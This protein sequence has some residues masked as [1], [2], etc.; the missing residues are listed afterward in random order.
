MFLCVT[1]QRCPHKGLAPR[2]PGRSAVTGIAQVE[3]GGRC[4]LRGPRARGFTLIELATVLAVIGIL[5][6][7]AIGISRAARRNASMGSATYEF[8]QRLR[9]LR[10]TAMV[11]NR[12]LAFVFANSTSTDAM[13][14]GT[15]SGDRC[16]RWWVLRVPSTWSITGFNPASPAGGTVEFVDSGFMPTGIHLDSS[17][18][19]NAPSP[20]TNTLLADPDITTTCSGR[21]CFAIR[22]GP[23]G[24]VS[25]SFPGTATPTRAGYAFG[26][27]SAA[28]RQFV[29]GVRVPRGPRELPQRDREGIHFLTWSATCLPLAISAVSP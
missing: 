21:S 23:D 26:L 9:S 5:A 27:A 24:R 1:N 15:F 3:R 10:S 16:A 25:P 28:S 4:A 7:V 22:F 8:V 19:F 29:Q 17:L 12:F 13:D 6:T 11:E 14:C 20:F 2:C 18:A